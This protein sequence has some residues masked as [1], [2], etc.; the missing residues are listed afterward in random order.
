MVDGRTWLESRALCPAIQEPLEGGVA[1]AKF[2][3]GLAPRNI[4]DIEAMHDCFKTAL[5]P[6]PGRHFGP[7]DWFALTAGTVHPGL[8]PLTD[9]LQLELGQRRQEV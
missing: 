7:A 4:S 8:D 3:R 5:E 2:F 1:D 9:H 6:S